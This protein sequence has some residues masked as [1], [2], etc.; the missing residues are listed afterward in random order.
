L[1]TFF[2]KSTNEVFTVCFKEGNALKLYI[3]LRFSKLGG[4]KYVITYHSALTGANLN[5][6]KAEKISCEDIGVFFTGVKLSIFQKAIVK[7]YTHS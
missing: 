7:L 6:D 4:K 2:Y 3:N 1:C 5:A